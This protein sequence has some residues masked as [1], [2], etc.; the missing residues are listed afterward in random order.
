MLQS[1]APCFEYEDD[2][3][4]ED[5]DDEGGGC[6]LSE[7]SHWWSIGGSVNGRWS[8]CSSV[9][10]A[11]GGPMVASQ[12]NSLAWTCIFLGFG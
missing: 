3:D 7:G 2:R 9:R 1:K 12:L 4:A 6:M 5:T 11:I 8:I 10:A